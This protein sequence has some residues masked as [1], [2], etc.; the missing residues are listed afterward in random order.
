[1][2]SFWNQYPMIK[3]DLDSVIDIMKKNLKC[4]DKFIQDTLCAL[5]DSGGKM[6][7][8]AFLLTAARFG[9]FVPEKIYPLAAC[10]E[11]LHMSTLVHDDI[12]DDSK[13]R[14]GTETIQSKYGKDYAVYM[15]DFLFCTCFK[16]L[17]ESTHIDEIKLDSKVLSRICIG[18]INQFSSQFDLDLSIRKY[19]RR[20][21]LK[22]AELFSLSFYTGAAEGKCSTALSRQFWQIGHYIG[23]AF[24]IIDD[25][26]DYTGDP[27]KVGKPLGTDI[28]QGIF[29]L[30]LIYADETS[31]DELFEI[32]SKKSYD[33]IDIKKIINIANDNGGI[34]KSRQLAHK[35]SNKAFER[36]NML[37]ENENK[38]IICEI[39]KK[40]LVRDY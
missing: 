38:N 12:I 25:I 20:I 11:M 17:S 14:R 31:H 34:E 22:T 28:K 29:T 37:P 24:Q 6:L 3:N 18:E 27:K 13:M 1:M 19:L 32:L 15:G 2:D 21:S 30:P 7:R 5:I 33:S 36:I 9:E 23:M 4:R 26:L 10:I 35:Y 40:L 16:I 8:P 39:T